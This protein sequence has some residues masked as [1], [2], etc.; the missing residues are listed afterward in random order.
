[1]LCTTS[2][3]P[4][5]PP[6]FLNNP[7]ARTHASTSSLSADTHTR[8]SGS[9]HRCLLYAFHIHIFLLSDPFS[10]SL[11][12]LFVCARNKFAFER[13]LIEEQPESLTREAQVYMDMSCYWKAVS[14]LVSQLPIEVLILTSVIRGLISA[15]KLFLEFKRENFESTSP[16]EN[17]CKHGTSQPVWVICAC[18]LTFKRERVL[19]SYSTDSQW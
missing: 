19:T 6:P 2:P 11:V 4:C 1:M 5:S 8:F 9:T 13:L 15:L 16:N 17:I 18:F 7:D 3:A 10:V 14:G 12:C